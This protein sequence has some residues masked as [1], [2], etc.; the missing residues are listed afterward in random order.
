MRVAIDFGVFNRENEQSEKGVN[1]ES[2]L[3]DWRRLSSRM[4]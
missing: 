3:R 1:H 2:K 4:E